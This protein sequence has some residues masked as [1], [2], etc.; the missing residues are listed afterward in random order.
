MNYTIELNKDELKI[1]KQVLKEEFEVEKYYRE[2]FTDGSTT[3]EKEHQ[4]LMLIGKL[5]NVITVADNLTGDDVSILG[6]RKY[7]LFRSK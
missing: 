3:S 6:K 4:L 1:L 2:T 5:D 7:G